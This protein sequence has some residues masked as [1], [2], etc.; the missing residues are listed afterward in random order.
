MVQVPAASRVAVAPATLHTDGVVTAKLTASPELDV[1]VRL[2]DVAADW[3]AIALKVRVCACGTR[4][5]TTNVSE[6]VATKFPDVP[7]IVTG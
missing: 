3:L 2:N 6:H 5:A 1:A 7:V 4:A